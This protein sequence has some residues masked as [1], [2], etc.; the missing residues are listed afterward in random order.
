MK[1][2]YVL[3]GQLLHK[4][5]GI[6]PAAWYSDRGKGK[7]MTATEAVICKSD[8]LLHKHF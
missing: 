2:H 1:M 4:Q 8:C 5:M 3:W 6:M 7:V